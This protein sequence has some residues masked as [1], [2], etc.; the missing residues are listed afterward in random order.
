MAIGYIKIYSINIGQ[1]I[2][3]NNTIITIV[4]I[5]MG[6]SMINNDYFC[7]MNIFYAVKNL[8]WFVKCL[9]SSDLYF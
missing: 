3:P 2:T 5:L 6:T 1:T 7:I 4:L 8:V 9:I